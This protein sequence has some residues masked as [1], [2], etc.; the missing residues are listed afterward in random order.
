MLRFV[1]R[2]ERFFYSESKARE[3]HISGLDRPLALTCRY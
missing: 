3:F 1:N 2:Q